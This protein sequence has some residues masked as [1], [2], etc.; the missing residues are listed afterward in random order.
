MKTPCGLKK[1]DKIGI[2]APAR[3]ISAEDVY[4]ATEIIKQ[5]GF[6]PVYGTNLFAQYN[7]FAGND[8][9]RVS[10]FQEMLDNPEIKAVVSVRGGY[11]TVRVIDNLNFNNFVKNPKWLAGYSDFTVVLNHVFENYNIQTLHATM[12]INFT[13]NTQESLNKF[14]DILN[15]KKTNYEWKQ[16]PLNKRGKVSG[17][18]VGGNLSVLY[19]LI[20]SKSFPDTTGKI[21][22]IE[23]LDEYLYHIDRMMTALKR[24]GKL[25]NLK[26]LLIGSM[27]DMND[28]NIA[29]GKTAEEIIFDTVKDYNY[30]VA[31][32]FQ[33]G[34]INNNLPLVIGGFYKME[35]NENSNLKLIK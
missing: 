17:V 13:Q 28:N 16:H 34:H 29:F 25:K 12:P 18:L 27:T 14:F 24:A 11:G 30:P 26:A 5:H 1:G 9:I 35:I 6:D 33:A 20:G 4:P 3:K 7:Q 22:F 21:L 10:D 19:S 15:G 31:M 8:K 32:G 2:I 23:D